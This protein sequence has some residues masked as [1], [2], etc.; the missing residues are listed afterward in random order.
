MPAEILFIYLIQLD[1]WK[2]CLHQLGNIH[3]ASEKV[4]TYSIQAQGQ[5]LIMLSI[6]SVCR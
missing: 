6:Q 1:G 3:P 4:V 2:Y 5:Q